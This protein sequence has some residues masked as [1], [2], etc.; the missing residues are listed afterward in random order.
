MTNQTYDV[1]NL[2]DIG[3]LIPLRRTHKASC[4]RCGDR[5]ETFDSNDR[6]IPCNNCLCTAAVIIQ[7]IRRSSIN[8]RDSQ[9][10]FD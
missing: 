6:I 8:R 2:D 3:P 7:R 9:N 5:T 4:H 10:K 1:Y